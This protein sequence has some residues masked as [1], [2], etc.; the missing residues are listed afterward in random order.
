M[1]SKREALCG[2]AAAASAATLMGGRPSSATS[3]TASY[4]VSEDE[5]NIS[6]DAT[7]LH[8]AETCFSKGLDHARDGC[9]SENTYQSFI[10][11]LRL[12]DINALERL[13]TNVPWAD[14]LEGRAQTDKAN[15]RR[16]NIR[17]FDSDAM[18]RDMAELYWASL[19]RD[20]AFGQFLT[21]STVMEA[22][23]ELEG[24]DP[25]LPPFPFRANL[26]GTSV[27]G[28]VSQFLLKPVP[29]NA[30]F[31]PQ[32]FACLVPASDFLTNAEEWFTVQNGGLVRTPKEY[33]REPRFIYNGRSLAEF[34]H[35]DFSFQAFL[36]AALILESWGRRA[37]NPGL[38]A[39]YSKSSSAFVKNG[40]PQVLAL[41]A[42]AS[43]QA[44]SDAWFWKW[45]VFRRL[46]PEELAGRATFLPSEK[47]EDHPFARVLSLNAVARSKERFGTTLLSQAY[48]E[49]SPFHP[50]FPAGH[51]EIA[52]ACI[53]ILKAFT[54]PEGIVSSPVQPSTD[55]LELSNYDA[56]LTIEGELN[57]LA[58]NIAIGRTF[59]GIHYRSDQM[60]GLVLGEEIAL[61]LLNV[62]A[63]SIAQSNLWFRRFD[64][65]WVTVK[66]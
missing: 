46:R 34:V 62:R 3:S 29:L 56:K 52:G 51:A 17:W 13:K 11:A 41:V 10:E 33:L 1:I 49:G 22:Q 48:P 65:S 40:W 37:L 8:E 66:V 20:V 64:G 50:S 16:L 19:C 21:N 5:W 25:T 35:N 28:F 36:S 4:S 54:D 26:P 44:L 39:R 12:R 14:P 32:K 30:R 2:L 15:F 42:E 58:W 6:P 55:G 43:Q 38:P 27:G 24:L 53:T 9:P 47:V 59:A 63:D 57:K 31:V 18:R 23:V 7:N 61:R 45:R 60:A